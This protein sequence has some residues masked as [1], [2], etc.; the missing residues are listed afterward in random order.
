MSIVRWTKWGCAAAFLLLLSAYF[1]REYQLFREIPA[2]SSTVP[3]DFAVYYIAS[4]QAAGQGDGTLY[5]PAT[6]D[7]DAAQQTLMAAVPSPSSWD[8]LAQ[9]RGLK[10]PMRYIYPPFFALLMSP[11]AHW[12]PHTAF[13]LWREISLFLLFVSVLLTLLWLRAEPLVP[14]FFVAAV[15]ALSFFP[16]VEALYEGQVDVLVLFLWV[17]GLYCL[18]Q[19][20]PLGS[21]ICFA[22]GTAVKISPVVVVPLLLLRRQWRWFAAYVATLGFLLGWSIWRL[23]WQSHVTY[24]TQ[25]FPS[26]SAGAPGLL[27][28]SLATVIH[29]VY[30]GHVPMGSEA[31]HTNVALTV[32]KKLVGG[33]VYAG[34]LSYFWERTKTASYLTEELAIMALVVLLISPLSWRHH[35]VLAQL[36]LLYLWIR[37]RDSEQTSAREWLALTSITVVMGTPVADYLA[38]MVH[39]RLLQIAFASLLPI[40]AS[41]ALF[42][43]LSKVPRPTQKEMPS[44]SDA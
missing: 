35:F 9:S 6:T 26:L 29:N 40:A 7:Q 32:V 37:T 24:V 14:L 19:E 11:L 43:A 13:F 27:G 17:G 15:A 25:V 34:V 4:L 33:L 21:A 31:W 3:G 1:Q 23:G 16:V 28:K 5:Y 2:A 42:L 22:L 41:A 39:N 30:L 44:A 10:R 8:N 38:L 18:H 36:P 12:P 20:Q